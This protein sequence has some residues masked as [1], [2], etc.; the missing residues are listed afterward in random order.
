[1]KTKTLPSLRIDSST[2]SKVKM[3]MKKL[4]ENSLVSISLQDFRRLSLETLSG[5]I[6][7]GQPL[8]FKLEK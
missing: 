1:M 6:L 4:N 7:S 5:L 8:P 2:E 3:A